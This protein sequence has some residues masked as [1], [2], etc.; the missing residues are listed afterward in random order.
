[1]RIV[2]FGLGVLFT[3]C[4][5]DAASESQLQSEVSARSVPTKSGSF[6]GHY[7][8]PTSANLADAALFDV[9]E[10]DWTVV[11]G[12]ATLHYDLPVGLVGGDLSVTLTGTMAPGSTKV[13]L[14]VGSGN[15][16]CTATSATVITCSEVFG[17]LGALPISQNVVVQTAAV[18]YPGPSSDRVA[19]ANIFS[20]DPIGTV[21]FDVSIPS[22]DDDHGGGHGGGGGHGPH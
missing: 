17:N 8:V 6:V 15:G 1:M 14:A 21:R 4:A 18:E 9:P 22:D 5:V 7:T 16:T 2:L 10:V 3:G 11:G 20:S 13:Q 19:V 12:I